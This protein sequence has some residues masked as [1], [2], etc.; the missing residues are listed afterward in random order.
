MPKVQV[1]LGFP[2][3]HTE[4]NTS[5]EKEQYE[6]NLIFSSWWSVESHI[7][8]ISKRWE[9]EIRVCVVCVWKTCHLSPD[10]C[11]YLLGA[12]VTV[13]RPFSHTSDQYRCRVTI[14]RSKPLECRDKKNKQTKCCENLSMSTMDCVINNNRKKTFVQC[15]LTF[16]DPSGL[17]THHS[18][19][20]YHK[21]WQVWTQRQSTAAAGVQKCGLGL[22]DSAE[23]LNNTNIHLIIHSYTHRCILIIIHAILFYSGSLRCSMK[24]DISIRASHCFLPFWDHIVLTEREK[25]CICSWHLICPLTWVG[26]ITQE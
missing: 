13:N 2:Q 17:N 19:N 14:M 26:N 15:L 21:Y 10:F 8:N 1:A 12:D 18:V 24:L 20:M 7:W 9:V 4:I 16:N 11:V 5:P 3:Q 6:V 23:H 22:L 25:D